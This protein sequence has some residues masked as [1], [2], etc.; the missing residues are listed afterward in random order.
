MRA[1][2]RVIKKEE[3]MPWPEEYFEEPKLTDE[4]IIEKTFRIRSPSLVVD[5]PHIKGPRKR[6]R[7]YIC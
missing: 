7:N 3:R 6:Q 1:N 5:Q 2:K 4:E